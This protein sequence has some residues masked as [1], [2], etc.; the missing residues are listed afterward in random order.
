M[1][2]I[3]EMSE[4]QEKNQHHEGQRRKNFKDSLLPQSNALEMFKRM[5]AKK[6]ALNMATNRPLVYGE[7]G[8]MVVKE[9]SCQMLRS[10]KVRKSKT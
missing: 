6:R 10:K 8:R 7:S 2:S 4:R 1:T 3:E 5:K 9:D